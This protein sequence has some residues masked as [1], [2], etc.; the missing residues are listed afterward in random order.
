[1]SF[2]NNPGASF[3]G[4]MHDPWHSME[5]FATTGLVPLIPYVASYYGGPV[6]SAAAQEGI[7]Y[8]SGNSDARTGK[9]IAKSLGSGFAKG[10]LSN[11]GADYFG[12]G[13]EAINPAT[14]LPWSETGSGY[15]GNGGGSLTDLNGSFSDYLNNFGLGDGGSFI[16]T[17]GNSFSLSPSAPDSQYAMQD[18]MQQARD[19]NVPS[20]SKTSWDTGSQ[21]GG[22]QD[23]LSNLLR[24][25]QGTSQQNSQVYSNYKPMEVARQPA[26]LGTPAPVDVQNTPLDLAAL[27]KALRG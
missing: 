20:G 16:S 22:V 27:I 2:W 8:F 10:Y 1:M 3:E 6:A 24:N 21:T 5:N 15:A 19:T 25:Q 17:D 7:D 26:F 18:V 12:G 14:D 23:L 11:L 4:L 13:G 9:G